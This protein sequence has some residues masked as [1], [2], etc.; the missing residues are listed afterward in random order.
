MRGAGQDLV[1]ASERRLGLARDQMR[2]HGEGV[3]LVPLLPQRQQRRLVDVIRLQR[4]ATALV[5]GCGGRKGWRRRGSGVG[6]R[7]CGWT[8]TIMS[9]LK[10]TPMRMEKSENSALATLERYAKSPLSR[11][12]PMGL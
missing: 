11:R 1:D 8:A 9:L 7:G 10:A 6:G 3:D 5:H 2:A 4:T 12:M